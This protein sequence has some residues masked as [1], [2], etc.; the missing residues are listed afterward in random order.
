[1]LMMVILYKFLF[2]LNFYFFIGDL[3]QRVREAKKNSILIPEKDV[4]F[5]RF[6]YK[7]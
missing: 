5:I 2:T 7:Y 4:F 3:L 1:M 6:S